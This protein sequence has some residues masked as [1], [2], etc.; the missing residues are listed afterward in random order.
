MLSSYEITFTDSLLISFMYTAKCA[1]FCTHCKGT[2][3]EGWFDPWQLVHCI[4]AKNINLGVRYCEGEVVKFRF[5]E[6]PGYE[7]HVEK[8]MIGVDVSISSG[9]VV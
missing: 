3:G 7:E 5:D 4:R 1:S 8:R 2:T 9:H 6:T